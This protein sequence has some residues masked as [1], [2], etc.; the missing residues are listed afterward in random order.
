ME[1]QSLAEQS[2]ESDEMKM[3]SVSAENKNST[4]TNEYYIN[5]ICSK[6]VVII[7]TTLWRWGKFNISIY[8]KDKESILNMNPLIINNHCGEFISTENGWEY[9]IEIQNIDSYSDQEKM[10]IYESIFEDIDN[11]VLYDMSILEDENGWE[12]DGTIY[13]IYCGVELEEI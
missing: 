10:A 2:T 4:Y 9:D 6:K 12:L 5:T 1:D 8:E 13:E 7:I 11:K 3:Y